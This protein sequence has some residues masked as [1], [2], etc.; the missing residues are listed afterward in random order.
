MGLSFSGAHQLA[1]AAAA[2]VAQPLV[3][4]DCPSRHT[5]LVTLGA[6][7]VARS[8]G[9]RRASRRALPLGAAVGVSRLVLGV[10]WPTD[11]LSGWAFAA[12]ALALA[13]TVRNGRGTD[14]AR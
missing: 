9:C 11:V 8:L 13:E 6:G 2:V 5:T 4:P 14:G 3:R 1:P 7:L 10:H 12:S